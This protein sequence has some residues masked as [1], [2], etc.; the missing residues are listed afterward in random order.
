MAVAEMDAG[1]WAVVLAVKTTFQPVVTD[2]RDEIAVRD[3]GN[4]VHGEGQ[5]AQ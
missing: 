5:N 3:V 4:G 2:A 1:E